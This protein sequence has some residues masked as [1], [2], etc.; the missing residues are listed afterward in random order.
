M[1][2]L[3]TCIFVTIEL[4]EYLDKVFAIAGAVLGMANVLLIPSICHLK[5]LAETKTQRVIDYMIIAFS[6]FMIFFGPLTV[7]LT[8]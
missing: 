5:L 6:I 3:L 7:I 2:I 8:W 1:G 4:E